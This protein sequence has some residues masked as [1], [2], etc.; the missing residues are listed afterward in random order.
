MFLSLLQIWMQCRILVFG[1][2][3]ALVIF[4]TQW[5]LGRIDMGQSKRRIEKK[6]D[7]PFACLFDGA[8]TVLPSINLP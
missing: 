6:N 4:Y 8:L 3:C 2:Q 5:L 7:P 1:P